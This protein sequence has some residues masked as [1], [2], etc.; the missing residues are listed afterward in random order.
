M[1]RR[2]R[3]RPSSWAQIADTDRLFPEQLRPL[4][5]SWGR[6]KFEESLAEIRGR[7]EG[8]IIRCAIDHDCSMI[9]QKQ[10]AIRQR[11]RRRPTVP[12][13]IADKDPIFLT[14]FLR[15]FWGSW[16]CAKIE[17]SL[18]SIRDRKYGLISWRAIGHDVSRV[19]QK[20]W[21]IHR[22]RRRPYF[23]T[24]IAD[25]D[26]LFLSPIIRPLL[27]SWKRGKF[28]APLSVIRFRKGDRVSRCVIY[29]D[30]ARIFQKPRPS[31][32]RRRRPS[33]RPLIA[34]K[35]P[36]CPTRRAPQEPLEFKGKNEPNGP[37]G[38]KEPQGP[39]ELQ[40]P[41]EAQELKDLGGPKR[42]KGQKGYR[43]Y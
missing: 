27:V 33:F 36:L 22:R 19:F 2:R 26:R 18:A 12:T 5:G 40:E 16:K 32:P 23:R 28:G 42:P 30:F 29:H 1:G 4:R 14:P 11:H 35:D 24:L 17:E 13:L 37:H 20:A 41:K 3:R 6:V 25:Y 21:P 34:D 43:N 7:Q 38:P 39:Q 31:H 8:L 15:P 10:M 9:L